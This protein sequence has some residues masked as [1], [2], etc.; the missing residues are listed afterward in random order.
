MVEIIYDPAVSKQHVY[1]VGKALKGLSSKVSIKAERP[2]PQGAWEWIL[3]A[4]VML[5]ISKGLIDGFLKEL[6]AGPARGLKK[7]LS[8]LFTKAKEPNLRWGSLDRGGKEPIPAAIISFEFVLDD[9]RTKAKFVLPAQLSEEQF[10]MA[11][12]KISEIMPVAFA[13]SKQRIK[14][15]K[16]QKSI[17]D[18]ESLRFHFEHR[19]ELYPQK[20]YGFLSEREEWIDVHKEHDQ[21]IKKQIAARRRK[22]TRK[23]RSNKSKKR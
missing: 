2:G 4:A 10:L 20:L 9:V 11:L 7:G 12:N 3:P 18:E 21:E 5:Y 23:K 13:H 6:G 15:L 17:S 19:E 8:N 1:E 14:S 22:E 16:E